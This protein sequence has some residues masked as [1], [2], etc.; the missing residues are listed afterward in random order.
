MV[1]KLNK[2][3]IGL[4]KISTKLTYWVGTP[5]SIIVHTLIFAGIFA[6]NFFGVKADQIL[7]ILTTAVS[8]EAIYLAI[9]I[10]MTVNR[11]TASLEA[12]EEDIEDI[13]EDVEELEADV[14]DISRDIDILQEKHK[15]TTEEVTGGDIVK[16][17]K[18]LKKLR[19]DIL[20]FIGKGKQ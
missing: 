18:K 13:Q 19:G 20:T 1:K 11:N 16:V 8:L 5:V 7:L 17:Q 2:R 3:I 6:L 12:V 4:E 15:S 10:Q 9:F 14:E